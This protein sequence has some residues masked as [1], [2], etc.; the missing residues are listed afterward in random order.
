MLSSWES[1]VRSQGELQNSTFIAAGHY[2]VHRY[3]TCEVKVFNSRL[4]FESI[5]FLVS[6][7]NQ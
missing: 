4:L 2:L 6:N 5:F 3:F 7:K 1:V